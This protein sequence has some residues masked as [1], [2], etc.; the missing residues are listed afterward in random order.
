MKILVGQ[1]Y[2]IVIIQLTQMKSALLLLLALPLVSLSNTAYVDYLLDCNDVDDNGMLDR[3]ELDSMIDVVL[4]DRTCPSKATKEILTDKDRQN[5]KSWLGYW[6]LIR[7]HKT[8]GDSCNFTEWQD[9]IYHLD[10][11]LF[12]GETAEGK[13][14]GKYLKEKA[15]F[16]FLGETSWRYDKGGEIFQFDL[17]ENLSTE[18]ICGERMDVTFIGNFKDRF[19]TFP[20]LS[21]EATNGKCIAKSYLPSS[22]HGKENSMTPYRFVGGQNGTVSEVPVIGYETYRVI[23]YD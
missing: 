16:Y 2:Q 6:K 22:C 3:G 19:L 13:R 20:Y 8:Q 1:L 23:F 18:Y 11:L 9:A 12:V 4:T 21:I 7:V 15:S 17:E 14:F 10:N 5:L